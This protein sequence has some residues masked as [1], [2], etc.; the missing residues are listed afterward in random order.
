MKIFD[1]KLDEDDTSDC[2]NTFVLVNDKNMT[3][4]GTYILEIYGISGNDNITIRSYSHVVVPGKPD[5]NN[6]HIY[7]DE[8]YGEPIELGAG[9]LFKYHVEARDKYD[10][11]IT[12]A[13]ESKLFDVEYDNKNNRLKFTVTKKK[14]WFSN[15]WASHI[16]ALF[17]LEDGVLYNA[18]KNLFDLDSPTRLKRIDTGHYERDAAVFSKGTVFYL[19]V[20]DI[21]L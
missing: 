4:S 17:K 14:G 11:L 13:F 12:E 10:N 16:K 19:P 2:K 6:F 7:K 15:Y 8:D 5:P 21:N 3:M 20:N 1:F 18:N 9:E